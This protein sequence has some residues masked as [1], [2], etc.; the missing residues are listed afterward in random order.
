MESAFI[1]TIRKKFF[2]QS[3]IF[4]YLYTVKNHHQKYT[5]MNWIIWFEQ[6]YN[7]DLMICQIS[8]IQEEVEN[9]KLCTRY[10]DWY[11]MLVQNVPPHNVL[12]SKTSF[13]QNVLPKNILSQNAPRNKTSSYTKCPHIQ[14]VLLYKT[15]FPQ[16]VL[17]YKMT[18][19]IKR[20]LHSTKYMKTSF[21]EKQLCW[22][23][24]WT[25]IKICGLVVRTAVETVLVYSEYMAACIQGLYN[26]VRVLCR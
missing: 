14:N 5:F 23:T 19:T 11:R 17:H 20:P 25:E 24:T 12:L 21:H 10:V 6:N 9:Q 1:R 16:N 2:F 4:Y 22:T 7:Y 3:S 8:L 13:L 15:S 26:T 18:F